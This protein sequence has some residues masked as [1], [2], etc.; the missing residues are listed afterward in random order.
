MLEKLQKIV[1]PSGRNALRGKDMPHTAAESLRYPRTEPFVFRLGLQTHP[2][3]SLPP[4]L[5]PLTNVLLV[6]DAHALIIA[7]I[8]QRDT[9]VKSRDF[10]IHL[11]FPAQGSDGSLQVF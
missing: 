3:S 2:G 11:F 9:A 5:V 1:F 10:L 6:A 8:L 4:D 7:A